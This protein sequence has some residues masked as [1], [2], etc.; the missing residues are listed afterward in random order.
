MALGKPAMMIPTNSTTSSGPS[1]PEPGHHRVRHHEA[2]SRSPVSGA[3]FGFWHP[4]F[5]T[6]HLWAWYPNP[7]GIYNPTNRLVRPFND[8]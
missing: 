1:L 6:L 5:V 2:A 7:D 4:T 8:D 3:K